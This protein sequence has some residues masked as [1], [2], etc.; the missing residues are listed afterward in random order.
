MNGWDRKFIKVEFCR[1]PEV[2]HRLFYGFSLADCA[3]FGAFRDIHVIFLV[4]YHF[5]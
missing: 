1:F 3:Y 5:E 2:C 4:H